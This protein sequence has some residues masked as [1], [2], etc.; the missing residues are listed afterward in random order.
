MKIVITGVTGV[1][2]QA[3]GKQ[4]HREGGSVVGVSRSDTFQAPWMEQL[5]C[6]PQETV[7]DVDQLLDLDPDVI[8]L[9]A[10]QIEREIGEKGEPMADHVNSINKV[11]YQ[12]PCDVAMRAM[13]RRW[14]HPVDII[15]IGSI[16]DC[17]PSSFGPVYHSSKIALHYFWTGVGP[18]FYYG[19]E[20]KIRLR[21]YR[22]GAIMSDLAWAPV[23]RLIP[24]GKGHQ[25]R[26]KRVAGAPTG[27]QVA[28]HF[29]SWYQ[30]PDA[31]VG[32]WGEP[33]SFKA[34][35][36][37]FGSFPNLF[38]KMQRYAWRKQSRFVPSDQRPHYP[39]QAILR[40]K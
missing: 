32:G 12:W 40:S 37:I 21:L 18:I 31:W 35:R 10:G 33:F 17:C 11:N 5:I 27:E 39:P 16:A 38:Y 3:L 2:G 25:M 28:T 15:A 13:Q 19:S 9:N 14:T 23:N 30:K 36:S 6:S 4:F 8:I 1:L 20:E 26:K 34:L 22:P 7:Q 24:E 29:Y